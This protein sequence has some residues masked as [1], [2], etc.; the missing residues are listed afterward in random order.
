[1]GSKEDIENG[2]GEEEEQ[3]AQKGRERGHETKVES[4]V[5]LKDRYYWDFKCLEKSYHFF[6][7]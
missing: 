6:A 7:A 4:K 5:G 2:M 1:M 3:R